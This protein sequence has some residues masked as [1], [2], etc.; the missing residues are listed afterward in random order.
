MIKSKLLFPGTICEEIV[1][2]NIHWTGLFLP[3]QLHQMSRWYQNMARLGIPQHEIHYKKP[4][5][6]HTQLIY[7]YC[8][9]HSLSPKQCSL[10]I[11]WTLTQRGYWE[12]FFLQMW[13]ATLDFITSSLAM[14]FSCFMSLRG[15]LF[16]ISYHICMVCYKCSF[17]SDFSLIRYQ[18]L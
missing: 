12:L 10:S 14:A 16:Y 13:S 18:L 4:Y 8:L 1:Y 17:L 11:I 7:I 2:Y 3:W 9:T 6:F 15:H 5:E